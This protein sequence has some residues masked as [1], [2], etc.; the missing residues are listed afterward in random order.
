MIAQ[1][2]DR[3]GT[4]I[5]DA[6][7]GAPARSRPRPRCPAGAGPTARRVTPPAVPRRWRP[8][9]PE[10]R[11]RTP[12]C[13]PAPR[14]HGVD[15]EQEQQHDHRPAHRHDSTGPGHGTRPAGC[16]NP[17]HRQR[18]A[19]THTTPA[20]SS[21]SSSRSH[22]RTAVSAV[23]VN[24][25]TP[26]DIAVQGWCGDAVAVDGQIDADSCAAL[27]TAVE[28]A[29]RT[30]RAVIIDLTHVRLSSAVGL[31]CLDCVGQLQDQ[32]RGVVHL[33]CAESSAVRGVL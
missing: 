29:T 19:S 13:A 2:E 20:T 4:G 16:C 11:F 14:T 22:A 1:G 21:P 28:Q 15:H 8:L 5:V 10:A 17:V 32:R 3:A 26:I 7:V 33:V 24:L 6:Y 18:A 9:P 30:H 23:G 12:R 27:A 25:G 31:H